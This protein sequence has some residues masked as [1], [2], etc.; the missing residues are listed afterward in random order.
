MSVSIK[1][2]WRT[3]LPMLIA[4]LQNGTATGVSMAQKELERMAKV[5]DVVSDLD[6]DSLTSIKGILTRHGWHPSQKQ[7]IENMAME[8]FAAGRAM[9][10]RDANSALDTGPM[11]QALNEGDGVYRP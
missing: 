10:W 3:S 9:G 8:L 4:V 6:A 5:A 11:D 1:M 7:V 2:N